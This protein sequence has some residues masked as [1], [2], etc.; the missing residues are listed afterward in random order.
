MGIVL[1]RFAL[2]TGIGTLIG[3]E[4]DG[5]GRWRWKWVVVMMMLYYSDAVDK[6][7]KGIV[8]VM[9]IS[10][11]VI[12]KLRYNIVWDSGLQLSYHNE[13]IVYSTLARNY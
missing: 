4:V 5:G 11:S 12:S 8:G 2:V 13:R 7:R 1:S 10:C 9:N 6:V 3:H